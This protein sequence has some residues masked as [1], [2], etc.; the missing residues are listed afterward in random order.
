MNTTIPETSDS[1]TLLSDMIDGYNGYEAVD[2][3]GQ[4]DHGVRQHLENNLKTIQEK[5]CDPPRAENGEEQERVNQVYQKTQRKIDT[6][7]SSLTTPTYRDAMFFS[8]PTLKSGLLDQIYDREKSLLENISTLKD[9]LD[10]YARGSIESDQVD[11]HFTYFQDFIDNF[12][13]DLFEREA[14]ILAADVY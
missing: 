2:V 6:I 9:E 14:L 8:S 7:C 1:R 5:L 10:A 4:S 11:E 13:Q 12:S 3:R